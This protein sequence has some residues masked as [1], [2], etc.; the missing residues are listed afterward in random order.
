MRKEP[1]CWLEAYWKVP[2]LN[3]SL[4]APLPSRGKKMGKEREKKSTWSWST[5]LWGKNTHILTAKMLRV[6]KG[7]K[8]GW[9]VLNVKAI[10]QCTL[11]KM[12]WHIYKMEFQ[13]SIC[14]SHK[15]GDMSVRISLNFPL[16]LF[17]YGTQ[18]KA[19][20]IRGICWIIYCKHDNV[21]IVHAGPQGPAHFLLRVCKIMHSAE[22]H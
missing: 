6:S 19:L 20:L 21:I 17:L 5:A 2:K 3:T 16:S 18:W 4:P 12:L 7:K 11:G 1:S 9:L 10:A 14:S 13:Q 8:R 22:L 15:G